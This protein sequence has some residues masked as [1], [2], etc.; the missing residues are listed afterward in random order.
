MKAQWRMFGKR[1][2]RIRPKQS[3]KCFRDLFQHGRIRVNISD[4]ECKFPALPDTEQ[5]PRSSQF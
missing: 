2:L 4:A 5:I 3:V 1:K